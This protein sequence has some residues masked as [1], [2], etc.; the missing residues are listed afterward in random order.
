MSLLADYNLPFAVA[1]V[2]MVL[3]GLVQAI[4][5][6]AGLGDADLDAD[7]DGGFADGLLSFLAIG[8]VPFMIWLVIYLLVFAG[9]GVGIQALAQ[10]LLGA[11]LDRWVAAAI[12]GVAGLP[13]TGV[14]VRPLAAILPGDESSAV[15]LDALVGRRAKIVTGRAAAG[16]PA[17]AEVHDRHGQPHYVMVEPH[18]DSS[19]MLEGDEL[20]LVRREGE[21][22]YGVPLQERRL[23]PM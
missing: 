21:S 17:R 20:L 15:G 22:F 14:L 3:L 16:H 1:L 18:E 19:E 2:L 9:A 10:N 23:A 7:A 5:L 11:P 12:A 6:G 13:V 4:G 8:R